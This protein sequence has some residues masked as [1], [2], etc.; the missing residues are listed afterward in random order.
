METKL[1]ELLDIRYPIIEGGMAYIGDGKLA[2]AVSNAGGLGQVG[3]AGRSEDDFAAQI[4][5]ARSLT[6]QPLGVNLPIG[7]HSDPKARIDVILSHKQDIQV[8]SLSAGNPKPY[9]QLL[10]NE[11]LHVLVVVSTALQARKA[12]EAGATAVIAEGS[13]AGGHNGPAELSTLALLPM[14]AQVSEVPVIAAGGIVDG[15]TFA[16]ALTL[17]A[18]GVQLGTRLVATQESCA[19]PRYK[20]AIVDATGEQ[21][22]VMERSIGR[23]T[24]VLKTKYTESILELEK[25]GITSEQLY[26]YIKGT[27][28]KVAALDG[29]LEHGY[30]YASQNCGLITDIPTV[31]ELIE[32]LVKDARAAL[33]SSYN[34]FRSK[35]DSIG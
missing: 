23:S 22:V 2:A 4:K 13:E 11:G 27:I 18:D 20:Q 14:V 35:G 32:R 10:R 21:T 9:I 1:T 17:G 30:A 12:V 8:V 29:D 19:H 7:E 5:L 26:P 33:E 6:S 15:R 3:S 16:A 28:N 25:Q 31:Q 24:R 34:A